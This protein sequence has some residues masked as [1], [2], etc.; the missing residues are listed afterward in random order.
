MSLAHCGRRRLGI[1]NPEPA[2]TYPDTI[3]GLR[4]TEDYLYAGLS[5]GANFGRH[6][7]MG[8]F[9]FKKAF[10]VIVAANPFSQGIRAVQMT[11]KIFA[12]KGG[13]GG[14]AVVPHPVMQPLTEQQ[15]Y[16]AYGQPTPYQSWGQQM[17]PQGFQPYPPVAPVSPYPAQGDSFSRQSAYPTDE[18]RQYPSRAELP[19]RLMPSQD[20]APPYSEDDRPPPFEDEVRPPRMRRQNRTDMTFQ[21]REAESEE[22]EGFFNPLDLLKKAAQK[23]KAS[24]VASIK[25]S[26]PGGAPAPLPPGNGGSK[27]PMWPV[28]VAGTIAGFFVVRAIARK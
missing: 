2:A 9:S 20:E 16:Q 28:Y 26:L 6:P 3:N 24:L 13:G 7:G 21:P 25:E 15:P 12:P 19:P 22:L 1:V 23:A 11:S 8:R 5:S 17:Y 10:R 4:G 27:F 18:T 14:V